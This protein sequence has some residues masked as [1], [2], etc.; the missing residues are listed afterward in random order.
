MLRALLFN[1]VFYVGTILTAIIGF[2]FLII[3]GFGVFMSRAWPMAVSKVLAVTVGT[4]FKV[5][6]KIPTDPVLI[7]SKHQSAWE[8]IAYNHIIHRPAFV[9]KEELMWIPFFGTYLKAVGMIALDRRGQIHALK[10]LIRDSKKVISE[11]RPILLFPEG[12]RA[13]PGAK[14]PYKKGAFMLYKNLGVPA[15]PVALNSG[16]FWPRRTFMKYKGTITVKFL[17]PIQP[18][19]SEEEFMS[20][21]E[22]DIENES[23]KLFH[24]V[25][26]IKKN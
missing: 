2:P 19:L 8:T 12:T 5:E 24:Q 10:K 16:I 9:L 11:G 7:L 18:G 6:G 22:A 3:K 14:V 25:E 20:R 13:A 1:I 15:V 23:L 17:P 26:N 4:T 21:I